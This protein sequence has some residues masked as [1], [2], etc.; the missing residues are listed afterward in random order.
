MRKK[1]IDVHFTLEN[2]EE[3]LKRLNLESGGKVQQVIDASV[4]R[5]SMP[6]IP[7]ETGTLA[8]SPYTATVI[9]SGEVVYPE[10]YAHY[11]YCGI[12]SNG[13]PLN[14]NVD[15]NPLAGSYWIERMKAAHM[16]DIIDEAKS[17]VKRKR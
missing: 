7:W 12:S 1:N 6:Y 2:D 5:Y 13:N 11:Q 8:R 4:I 14:Y 3:L 9:G 17:A 15:I 10:P 16:R